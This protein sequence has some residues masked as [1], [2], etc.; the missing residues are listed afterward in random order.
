MNS[1]TELSDTC[2]QSRLWGGMHFTASIAGSHQLCD[3]I[4][5]SGYQYV[6]GLLNGSPL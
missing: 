3:G 2:G 1:L 4:G 5:Q 6:V